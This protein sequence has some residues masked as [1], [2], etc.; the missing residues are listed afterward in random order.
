MKEEVRA[1]LEGLPPDVRGVAA[2]LR[3]IVRQ[4]IPQTEES[5]LW[6]SLSYHRPH[7]GGRVKGAVCLIV[8]KS[9]RIHLEF[10]HG[11][12]LADPSRLLQGR[13]RSKRYIPI[14]DV[15]DAMRPEI[16]ALIRNAAALDPS[17][18]AAERQAVK[19]RRRSRG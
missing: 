16:A 19:S 6:R 9:G 17:A 1:Y 3:K 8:A 7:V 2:A 12:R 13:L 10:I 11:V 14:H 15:G 4:T 5:I 18:W